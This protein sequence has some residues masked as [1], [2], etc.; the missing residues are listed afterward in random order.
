MGEDEVPQVFGRLY[1]HEP[2]GNCCDA[3]KNGPVEH[4]HPAKKPL[5]HRGPRK[6]SAVSAN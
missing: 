3:C 6:N 2:S 1:L 5:S 4:N